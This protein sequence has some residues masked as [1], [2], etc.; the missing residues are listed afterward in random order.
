MKRHPTHTSDPQN[1][2]ASKRRRHTHPPPSPDV[3]SPAPPAAEATALE[4]RPDGIPSNQQ[5]HQSSHSTKPLKP[6]LQ[7]F[8]KVDSLRKQAELYR[9]AVAELPINLLNSLWSCG[10]NRDLE[11]NHVAH[12]CRSFRQGNLVRRAEENYI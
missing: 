7:L 2:T 3:S 1:G 9:L 12:L 6:P 10:N 5:Q 11:R 8:T 4:L